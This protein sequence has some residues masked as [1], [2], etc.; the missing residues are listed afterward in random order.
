MLSCKIN[1]FEKHSSKVLKLA[2]N[3]SECSENG[4]CLKDSLNDLADLLHF[5]ATMLT[6]W[7]P[8]MEKAVPLASTYSHNVS[9]YLTD[10]YLNSCPGFKLAEVADRPVG[11]KDTPFS[12]YETAT[13]NDCL[14]PAGFREGVTYVLRNGQKKTTGILYMSSG[15]CRPLTQEGHL[16]LL[17]LTPTLSKIAKQINDEASVKHIVNLANSSV[18]L[19]LNYKTIK[20]GILEKKE[21]LSIAS[22]LAAS[23]NDEVLF[24]QQTAERIW[25]KITFQYKR[26]RE[27]SYV[28]VKQR[29]ECPPMAL[30][31]RELEIANLTCFG[32]TNPEIANELGISLSTV[33]SHLENLYEKL[34]VCRRSEVP[35]KVFQHNLYVRQYSVSTQLGCS[36]SV[37]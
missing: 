19:V 21:M 14:A 28:L 8:S 26:S 31:F 16:M 13:Y 22:E 10:A 7:T 1:E 27:G 17:M 25:W 30:T 2:R 9:S 11:M 33:K 34:G 6:S 5:D 32:F 18:N 36:L 23:V 24:Y 15:H 4:L 29:L 20:Q 3:L 37:N 12:F 35:M